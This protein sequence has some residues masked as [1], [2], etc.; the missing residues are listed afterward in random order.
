MNHIKRATRLFLF[1]F[2][3]VLYVSIL[4]ADN[5]HVVTLCLAAYG[6]GS[7]PFGYLL[8]RYYNYDLSRIGSGSIGATNVLR[9]GR[10]S[11]AALTLLLDA[12]KGWLAVFW[13]GSYGDVEFMTYIIALSAIVGH[14]APLWLDFKGGKGVA[15]GFGVMLALHWP[16]AL[17]GLVIWI[18]CALLLRL[19]SLAAL[20]TYASLPPLALVFI[21]SQMALFCLI[22]ATLVFLTH[23]DNI[24]RLINGKEPRIGEC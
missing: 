10:K 23:M 7:I 11:L 8:A 5:H 16:L 12:F 1:M 14:L 2:F 20:V 3:V 9:T 24:Q 6:L 13:L 22:L 4:R 18:S 15:T 17:T 21:N 19:S